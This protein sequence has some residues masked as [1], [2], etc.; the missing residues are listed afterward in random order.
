MVGEIF[1]S[2][3]FVVSPIFFGQHPALPFPDIS[4]HQCYPL[5]YFF[6]FWSGDLSLFSKPSLPFFANKGSLKGCLFRSSPAQSALADL[7]LV[8]PSPYG[9]PKGKSG[10]L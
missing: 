7:L 3:R 8:F 9:S 2:P 6:S 10:F 4:L 5:D 1:H